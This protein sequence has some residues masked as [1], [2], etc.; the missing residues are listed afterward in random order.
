MMEEYIAGEE[1]VHLEP[2]TETTLVAEPEVQKEA[3]NPSQKER[4]KKRAEKCRAKQ[5]KEAEDNEVFISDEAYSFWK[6]NMSDKGFI[7]ERGF[8]TLISLFAEVIEKRGWNLYASTSHLVMLKW[9]GS[10]TPV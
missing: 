4:K 5:A 10:S 8:S 6:E 7:G 9:S 2:Q 3:Q 1:E